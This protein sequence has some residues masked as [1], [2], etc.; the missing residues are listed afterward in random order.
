MENRRNK[1]NWT[2][3]NIIQS[4]NEQLNKYFMHK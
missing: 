4:T 2:D 3:E 1:L